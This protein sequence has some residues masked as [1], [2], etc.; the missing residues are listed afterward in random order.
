[1]CLMRVKS[2]ALEES[3]VD[4]GLVEEQVPRAPRQPSPHPRSRDMQ[5]SGGPSNSAEIG[6]PESGK[7]REP[8]GT[9]AGP[10]DRGMGGLASGG[11]GAQEPQEVERPG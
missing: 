1:M 2:G 8:Q 4:L 6:M 9:S 10:T 11:G 3:L 5:F 7:L